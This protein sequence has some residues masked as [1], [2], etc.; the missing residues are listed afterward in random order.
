MKTK[1]IL[2]LFGIIIFATNLL[3]YSY[4][5]NTFELTQDLVLTEKFR[6]NEQTI[7]VFKRPGNFQ[8]RIIYKNKRPFLYQKGDTLCLGQTN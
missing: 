8:Y 3:T 1:L 5:S 6:Q 2:F 7:Y 4:A